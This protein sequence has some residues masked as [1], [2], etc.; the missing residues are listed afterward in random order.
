MGPPSGSLCT[1]AGKHGLW[2]CSH[3]CGPVERVG[4]PAEAIWVQRVHRRGATEARAHGPARG[5]TRSRG[6]AEAA[7][8]V[9]DPLDE[10]PDDDPDD[11]DSDDEELDDEDPSDDPPEDPEDPSDEDSALPALTVLVVDVL[12]ESVR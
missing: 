4:E 6:Q 10:E 5:Q 11:E 3:R 2:S 9:L 1:T 8:D 12:R 7:F